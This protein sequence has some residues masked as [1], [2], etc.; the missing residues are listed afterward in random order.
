[1][2]HQVL[3]ARATAKAHEAVAADKAGRL[4]DAEQ[5]YTV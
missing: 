1:M 2:A 5:C 4:R 3:V